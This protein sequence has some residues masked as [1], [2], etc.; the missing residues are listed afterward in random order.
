MIVEPPRRQERQG[1]DVGIMREPGIIAD[2]LAREVI[3]AAIEVH[4]LLINFNEPILKTGIKRIVYSPPDLG[5][6]GALAV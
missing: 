4:R 1:K 3:G 5:V 2:T 6:L